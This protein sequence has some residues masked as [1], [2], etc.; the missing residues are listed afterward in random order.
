M[1]G[2]RAEFWGDF[3]MQMI[4]SGDPTAQQVKKGIKSALCLA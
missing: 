1:E 4:T 3:K 2:W